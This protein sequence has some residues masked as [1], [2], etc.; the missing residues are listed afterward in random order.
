MINSIK[1]WF[2]HS[3]TIL[4]ARL[5]MF[6]GAVWTVLLATD[7]SP[8]LDP[9]YLTWWL[10]FSGVVSELL[11]RR[12]TTGQNVV[13]PTTDADGS[14]KAVTTSYLASPPPGP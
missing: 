4:W 7:L 1:N 12:G 14:S 2:W 5:Q 10:V 9:K 6:V 8:T 13:V 3:E 11:R